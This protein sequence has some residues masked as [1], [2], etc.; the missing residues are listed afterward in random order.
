MN[1]REA[2]AMLCTRLPEQ[3][4]VENRI[5]SCNGWC[6]EVWQQHTR[7]ED[8]MVRSQGSVESGW[9]GFEA[10]SWKHS[11][12]GQGSRPSLESAEDEALSPLLS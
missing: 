1:S 6:C 8:F 7:E 9:S 10:R 5:K 3:W 12:H 2:E 11:V 4:N